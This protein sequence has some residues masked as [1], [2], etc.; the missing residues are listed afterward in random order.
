MS[1]QAFTF[2]TYRVNANIHV[3]DVC[4]HPECLHPQLVEQR[5][6]HDQDEGEVM[7]ENILLLLAMRVFP[8]CIRQRAKI[9]LLMYPNCSWST[10]ASTRSCADI[11]SPL[12]HPCDG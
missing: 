8:H 11:M 9:T 6:H 1:M 2:T 4:F 12:T 10:Q 7:Q 3:H 5:T